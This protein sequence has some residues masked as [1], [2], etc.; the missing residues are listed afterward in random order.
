MRLLEEGGIASLTTNAVAERAG[1]SVG[2]LYQYFDGKE[3]LLDALTTRE[4]GEM[5]EKIVRAMQSAVV[6]TPG[7]RIRQLVRVVAGAYRGRERV[8][9]Q[10]I[11]HALTKGTSGRLSPTHEQIATMFASQGVTLADGRIRELTPAQAFVVTH[12]TVGTLR[13]LAAQENPPPIKQ[14]EDAL[15]QMVY[16]YIA[17]LNSTATPEA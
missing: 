4:L 15:V 10:L 7:E 17:R 6:S 16:G 13:A 12:A 1:V 14:V 9:R 8:H 2:T 3:S 11:E 5:R